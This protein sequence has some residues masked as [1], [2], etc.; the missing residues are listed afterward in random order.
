MCCHYEQV[1]AAAAFL[2]HELQTHCDRMLQIT[3]RK[4]H[5]YQFLW[6]PSSTCGRLS[7]LLQSGLLMFTRSGQLLVKDCVIYSFRSHSFSFLKDHYHSSV[8]SFGIIL[9]S[10]TNMRPDRVSGGRQSRWCHNWNW[11]KLF[12]IKLKLE[13][14]EVLSMK[15]VP[16]LVERTGSV[17]GWQIV[18]ACRGRLWVQR[19]KAG[20]TGGI[21]ERVKSPG[22]TLLSLGTME[23]RSRYWEEEK[24]K[25][26]RRKWLNRIERRCFLQKSEEDLNKSFCKSPAETPHLQN[27]KQ[28]IWLFNLHVDGLWCFINGLFGPRDH[29]TF[30]VF[31]SECYFE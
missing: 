3:R 2:S 25:Q 11:C 1:L 20:G 17:L 27:V 23:L 28:E 29:K 5:F 13:E 24:R 12:I 9:R 18:T 31:Q 7:S 14:T 8:D 21:N 26:R 16:R 15:L 22:L 19:S 10:L 30:S 4:L 6:S